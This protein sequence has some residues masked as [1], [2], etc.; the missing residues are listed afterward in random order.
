MGIAD[1]FCVWLITV[2]K[3]I[4]KGKDLIGDNLINLTIAEIL[5]EPINDGLI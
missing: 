3:A 4:Q 2:S 5:A 1:S